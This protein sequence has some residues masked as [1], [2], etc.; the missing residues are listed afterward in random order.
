METNLLQQTLLKLLFFASLKYFSLKI[1][2][3]LSHATTDNII[4][5]L[6]IIEHFF[7]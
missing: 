3:I 6:K 7:Y 4:S 2:F 1:M 5:S